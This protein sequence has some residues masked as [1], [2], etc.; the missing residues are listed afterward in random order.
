[1]HDFGLFNKLLHKLHW[2]MSTK[3]YTSEIFSILFFVKYLPIFWWSEHQEYSMV[4][5]KW[6]DVPLKWAEQK[7]HYYGFMNSKKAKSLKSQLTSCF[8]SSLIWEVNLQPF[9]LYLQKNLIDFI[10]SR[11]IGL[12]STYLA[13]IWWQ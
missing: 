10:I 9:S 3:C 12:M 5:Q 7:L 8:F 4:L 2:N 1:M 13:S 6:S 11:R